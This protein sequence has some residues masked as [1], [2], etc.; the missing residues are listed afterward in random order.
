MKKKKYS[1]NIKNKK[2]GFTLIE[3][4]AVVLVIAILSSVAIISVTRLISKNRTNYYISQE[5]LVSLA[6]KNYVNDYKNELPKEIGKIQKI[7]LKKLQ[8]KNYISDVVD[9]KKESCYT[10]KSYV[11]VHKVSQT[12]YKYYVYLECPDYTIGEEIQSNS[13]TIEIESSNEGSDPHFSVYIQNSN[14]IASYNYILYKNNKE[15]KNSGNIKNE[16]VT[17][18]K[19]FTVNLKKYGNGTY[20]LK[21]LAY[22]KYGTVSIKTSDSIKVEKNLEQTSLCGKTTGE[23][24]TWTNKDR[25]I[26][27]SCN[28]NSNCTQDTYTK[29]FTT[30]TKTGY[31]EVESTDGT[32]TN[33]PVSVYVDKTPPTIPNVNMYLFK[34]NSV[35]PTIAGIEKASSNTSG[36]GSSTS[37]KPY[38]IY[39]SGKW[40][41]KNI[42]TYADGS[43]DEHSKVAYYQYT[44]TGTTTNDTN[45]TADYRSIEANGTSYIKY[46]ACDYA[47]NCSDYS[48]V[49]TIK[50][51]K[52]AP[53]IPNINMYKWK[54]NSNKPTLEEIINA[55]ATTT[56]GSVTFD[57]FLEYNSGTW[58]DKKVFTYP[59]GSSDS[60]S[61][62]AYYQYTTTGKTTNDTNKTTTYRNIEAEGT[63]YI[64]Y[65]ACDNAGNCSNYTTVSTINIDM[66]SPTC[67]ITL[68]GTKGNNNWYKSN[69][70]TSM[71]YSDTVGEIST[72]GLT[73]DNDKE[74]YNNVS[75]KTHSTDTTGVKYYGYVK[76]KAGN[77]GKC[78]STTFK[79]DK[80]KPYV[81]TLSN[82]SLNSIT[83][84]QKNNNG[85]AV[86]ASIKNRNCNDTT[87]TCTALVCLTP[88]VGNFVLTD[89]SSTLIKDKTS[90]ISVYNLN[91]SMTSSSGTTLSDLFCNKNKGY[92]PCTYTWSYSP[93]DNAGNQYSNAFKINYTI[94]YIGLDS[95][96]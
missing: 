7:E 61:G 64:K 30:T 1:K 14:G 20:K 42:F 35:T 83:V 11:L 62:L 52:I 65:R 13:A 4:L 95:G 17:Q 45:K 72:F 70:T 55:N 36:T 29:T 25:T 91:M 86:T 82:S 40:S 68:S 73:T 33:C 32:K 71:S 18:S 76:D 93:T 80:T 26:T 88:V 81:V 8:D 43:T 47:G 66:T 75:T 77:T 87:K 48:T 10:D 46:R 90:G 63:S 38:N 49:S 21:V 6:G 24:T 23:S 92:N 78:E 9:Y 74:N 57:D 51:D 19:T 94:G 31:I 67:R 60:L 85:D 53:T 27:I 16:G 28:S 59:S 41:N 84:T 69:V 39:T 15:I 12:K 54:N 34:T 22:D 58:S 79:V 96:C 2:R 56:T 50:I 5:K 89:P 3:L 37:S 44:T